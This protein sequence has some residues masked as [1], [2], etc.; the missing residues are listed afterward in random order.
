MRNA[1]CG[2]EATIVVRFA[3]CNAVQF[4][5]AVNRVSRID[6]APVPD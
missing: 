5:L 3:T 1:S 2:W 6:T 4:A